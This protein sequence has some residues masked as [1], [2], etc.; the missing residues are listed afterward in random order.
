MGSGFKKKVKGGFCV[1]VIVPNSHFLAHWIYL[2][3]LSQITIGGNTFYESA[4][5][6]LPVFRKYASFKMKYERER[7]DSVVTD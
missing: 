4:R 5:K 1:N 6:Y 2:M 3:R 7:Y